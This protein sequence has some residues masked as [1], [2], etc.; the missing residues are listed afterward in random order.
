M[1][2]EWVIVSHCKNQLCIPENEY[3]TLNIFGLI[4]NPMHLK[5]KKSTELIL[6][7]MRFFFYLGLSVLYIQTTWIS[8]IMKNS[9]SIRDNM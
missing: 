4:F 2:V 7:Y 3:R 9:G 5:K 8:F 6:V 1:H